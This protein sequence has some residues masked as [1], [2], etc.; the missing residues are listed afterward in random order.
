MHTPVRPQPLAP[1]AVTTSPNTKITLYLLC[2]GFTV[3]IVFV[4][5]G[6][7]A[8]PRC[9]YGKINSTPRPISTPNGGVVTSVPR[10]PT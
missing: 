2:T 4:R 10:S 9:R 7:Q 3:V 5:A 1:V 6:P 8:C